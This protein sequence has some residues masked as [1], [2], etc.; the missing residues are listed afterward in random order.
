MPQAALEKGLQM[1]INEYEDQCAGCAIS[2]S[3]APT[4]CQGTT[5][6]T[7]HMPINSNTL[8]SRELLFTSN[9]CITALTICKITQELPPDCCQ[10]SGSQ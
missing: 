2:V 6:F 4:F 10:A 8:D 5:T 3:N 9:V 7:E 1:T